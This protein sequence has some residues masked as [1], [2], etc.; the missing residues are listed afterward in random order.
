VEEGG[1]GSREAGPIATEIARYWF[2]L[3]KNTPAQND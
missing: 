1:E 3:G 2:D